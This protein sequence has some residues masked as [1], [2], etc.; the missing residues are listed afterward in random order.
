MKHQNLL[1]E[2]RDAL[3]QF[4]HQIETAG[5]MQ[6]YDINKISEDLICGLMRELFDLPNLKNL[7]AE[8][9]KNYP[10]I[11][12]ADDTA[13]VAIQV[14]ATSGIEKIKG[15]L[16]TFISHDLHNEYDRLI[17]YILGRKQASYSQ[18]AIDKICDSK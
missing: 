1:N 8:K 15:T 16:E 11:D 6:L 12:L 17:V 2:L 4:A 7:N 10:G 14:T 5:A 13:R 3:S 9:K 18:V